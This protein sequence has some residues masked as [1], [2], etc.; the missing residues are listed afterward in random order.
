M[1]LLLIPW[2]SACGG[3]WWSGCMGLGLGLG[4]VDDGNADGDWD[5]RRGM[6]WINVS[7]RDLASSI[8]LCITRDHDV[9]SVH[10]RA[11]RLPCVR[12][13]S[14]G[15]HARIPCWTFT[16]LLRRRHCSPVFPAFFLSVRTVVV[17]CGFLHADWWISCMH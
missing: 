7:L 3:K 16:H 11:A 10:V 13:L 14:R 17:T 12:T 1:Y 15:Y 4:V 6:D 2:P 9:S 5:H 8:E